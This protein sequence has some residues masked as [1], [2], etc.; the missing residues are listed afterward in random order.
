MR[1][2][3]VKGEEHEKDCCSGMKEIGNDNGSTY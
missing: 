1:Q 3:N 2:I